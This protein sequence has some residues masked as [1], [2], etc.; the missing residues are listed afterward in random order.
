MFLS[1][2]TWVHC[3][4]QLFKF[5]ILH[6]TC[7]GSEVAPPSVS[8]GGNT[9][10]VEQGNDRVPA[11][12]KIVVE[13]NAELQSPFVVKQHLLLKR[14]DPSILDELYSLTMAFTDSESK[15]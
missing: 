11:M 5:C 14:P 15:Q 10:L 9:E 2:I 3:E 4:L 1:C 13:P 6:V 7:T 8:S 12:T